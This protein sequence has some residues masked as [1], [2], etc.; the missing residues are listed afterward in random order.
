MPRRHNVKRRPRARDIE[1]YVQGRPSRQPP[2]RS[3]V[4]KKN[5]LKAAAGTTKFLYELDLQKECLAKFTTNAERTVS[6]SIC[7]NVEK[8]EEGGSVNARLKKGVS[9]V[10]GAGAG[11]RIEK[12]YR[13]NGNTTGTNPANPC[14][15][16]P[17]RAAAKC[18]RRSE[19][20]RQTKFKASPESASLQIGGWRRWKTR[21]K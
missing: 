1:L 19:E 5:D 15:N 21:K 7:K 11:N 3:R 2:L 16:T 6:C 10:L 4:S 20:E 8:T 13:T 17:L 14:T 12:S 9:I 18:A